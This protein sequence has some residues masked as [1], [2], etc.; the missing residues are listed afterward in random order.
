ML[1]DEHWQAAWRW[2][3]DSRKHAPV[4]ADV[5]HLRF[6]WQN[7]AADV[8]QQVRAGRYRLTPMQVFNENA[9]WSARDALVLKWVALQ[10]ELLLPRHPRCHHVKGHGGCRGSLGKVARALAGGE[11]RFVLRTD[12]RGYYAAMNKTQVLAHVARFVHDPVV[13]DLIAQYVEYS[14]ESGG[15]LHTPLSGI[16]RGCALSPLLGASFLYHI[17]CYFDAQKDHLFYA[18][19]MDDFLILAKTRWGLRRSIRALNQFFDYNGFEKHPQ[20][21]QMGK[22][23]KGFDWLGVYFAAGKDPEISPRAIENHRLRC[24]RLYEQARRRGLSEKQAADRVQRYVDR[25]KIWARVS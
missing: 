15:V 11:Y 10:T 4:H 3:K 9:Q 14:V 18:R 12:I 25:W 16:C 23:E 2:L 21:T 1:T 19:Y 8:Y 24:L 22:L 7:L 13:Y 5:W 6:H 17:D 20:K